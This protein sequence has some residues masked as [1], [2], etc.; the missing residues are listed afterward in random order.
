M[1]LESEG[2]GI[3]GQCPSVHGSDRSSRSEQTDLMMNQQSRLFE[4]TNIGA[5]SKHWASQKQNLCYINTEV[6]QLQILHSK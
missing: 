2:M 4:I 5:L 1:T 6:S 3:P